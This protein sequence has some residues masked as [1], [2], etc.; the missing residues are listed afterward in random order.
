MN[1]VLI[2]SSKQ[3]PMVQP[4]L[5]RNC[6][7]D[8]DNNYYSEWQRIISYRFNIFNSNRSNNNVSLLLII[9]FIQ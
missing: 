6:S 2:V 1:L 3:D 9:A 7:L 8:I 4:T 5:C